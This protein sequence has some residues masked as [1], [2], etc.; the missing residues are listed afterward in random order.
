M[1]MKTVIS[2][3]SGTGG[4][5]VINCCNHAW[6]LPHVDNGAVTPSASIKS[7]ERKLNDYDLIEAID[8][9]PFDYIG[10]HSVDR[11]LRMPV[12]SMWL[13][14]PVYDQMWA[15]AA[16]DAVTR[17]TAKNLMGKH[18]SMYEQIQDLIQREKSQQAAE[19][20]LDWLHNYNWT[21]MQM[22]LVQSSNKI[23][24]G[25][26]LK[27]GGIDSVIDQLPELE[28]VAPQCRQYHH[29]WLQR[30]QPVNDSQWVLDCVATKLKELVQEP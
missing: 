22:R 18:G 7:L 8:R 11:L 24:I 2:Y 9:M 13:V 10:S 4:D 5:F 16:R 27:S 26:L 6:D 28:S 3:V 17:P 25:M 12:R 30:Q 15:W 20:Y 23:D 1:A 14:I 29:D 19:L 21:L